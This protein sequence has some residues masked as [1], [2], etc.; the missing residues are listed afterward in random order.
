MPFLNVVVGCLLHEMGRLVGYPPL[1]GAR[2]VI[3]VQWLKAGLTLL[4][5][6]MT[7]DGS[8]V[9]DPTRNG[10]TLGLLFWSVI[11]RKMAQGR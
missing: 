2:S 1:D 9:G 8:K 10:S 11:R 7:Q 5:C 4:V 6:D 3:D